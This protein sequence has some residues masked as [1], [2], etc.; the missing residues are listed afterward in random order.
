[1]N[2]IEDKF[3]DEHNPFNLKMNTI[4]IISQKDLQK[5]TK[6]ILKTS[7]KLAN[8]SLKKIKRSANKK[9]Q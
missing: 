9:K 1:M 5:L 2:T 8:N 4:K 3:K 6:L 7:N